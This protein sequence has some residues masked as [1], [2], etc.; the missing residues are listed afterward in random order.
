MKTC[1]KCGAEKPLDEF[2]RN[3]NIKDGRQTICKKCIS[4]WGKKYR[5]ENRELVLARKKKYYYDNRE[6]EIARVLKWHNKKDREGNSWYGRN[7]EKALTRMVVYRLNNKEKILA[8]DRKYWSKNKD[9]AVAKA[10]VRRTRKIG[11]GGSFIAKEFNELCASYGYHC[12][13]CNQVKK[14]EADHIKPVK[15]LGSSN[16]DNIQPLCRSCNSSKGAKHIDY[17]GA[18]PIEHTLDD[19]LAQVT[20]DNLHGEVDTGN[21]VGKECTV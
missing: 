5:A 16:I 18:V 15:Y 21:A 11:G 2:H 13:C 7:R 19:L 17:R 14:L 20:P 6:S 12:L 8:A 3:K 10:A 4:E 9:K 1:T